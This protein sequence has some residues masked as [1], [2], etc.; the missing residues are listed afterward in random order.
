MKKIDEFT[1]NGLY[2]VF[3]YNVKAVVNRGKKDGSDED[4]GNEIVRPGDRVTFY[5]GAPKK[6]K[7][8]KG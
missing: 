5:H 8:K 6:N 1:S 7:D 2:V 3:T 4:R